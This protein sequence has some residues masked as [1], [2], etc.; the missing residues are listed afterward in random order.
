VNGLGTERRGFA[1]THGQFWQYQAE[2]HL[3]R[4]GPWEKVDLGRRLCAKAIRSAREDSRERAKLVRRHLQF[5]AGT[6]PVRE[7]SDGRPRLW[8][9]S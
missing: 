2:A 5:I 7:V 9:A 3:V 1:R 4:F 6:L 8:L